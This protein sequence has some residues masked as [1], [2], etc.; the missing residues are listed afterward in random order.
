M[1]FRE[2]K[3]LAKGHSDSKLKGTIEIHV[4]FNY[5]KNTALSPKK[6]ESEAKHNCQHTKMIHSLW[7]EREHFLK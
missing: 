2:A 6:P 1:R 4:C 3:Q 5:F 7:L